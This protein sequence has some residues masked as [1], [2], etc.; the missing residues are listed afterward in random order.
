MMDN[1]AWIT[2][3]STTTSYTFTGLSHASHTVTV[4]AMDKAGNYRDVSVRFT[5]R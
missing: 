4:R 1:G 2:L 3:S 5:V